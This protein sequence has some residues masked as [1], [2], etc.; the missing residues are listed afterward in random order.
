MINYSGRRFRYMLGF[1]MPATAITLT[2][3][4]FRTSTTPFFPISVCRPQTDQAQEPVLFKPSSISETLSLS[5]ISSSSQKSASSLSQ[6]SDLPASPTFDSRPQLPFEYD[7]NQDQE[8]CD[9]IYGIGYFTHIEKH[10]HPYCESSSSSFLQCF[11]APRLPQ[12]WASQWSSTAGDPFCFARGV[13][14]DPSGPDGRHFKASCNTRDFN[15]ERAKGQ[16]DPSDPL[17]DIAGV[18][19]LA[20]LAEYWGGSGVAAQFKAHWDLKAEVQDCDRDSNGE[21]LFVISREDTPNIWHEM[22]DLWQCLITLDAMQAV[23]NPATGEPWMTQEDIASMQ[24]VFD[25]DLP[26]QRHLEDWWEMLNGKKPMKASE[27]K[28]G[29]CYA[30]V[31]LPL[32]G[33]SSP[34]WGALVEHVYHEPCRSSIIIDAFR[35]RVFKH[36]DLT[37]RPLNSRPNEHPTITFVNRTHNRRLWDA[38]SLMDKIRTRY[39]DSK[40]NVVDFANLPLRE[41]VELATET[42]VFIGHHGA[43]MMHLFFL[44][45]DAAVV[46]IT[47]SRARKFRSITRMRGIT[48]FEANC[49]EEPDY[50]HIAYGK[51]YPQNWRAGMDDKHWQSR[52]YA[53]LIEEDF[54]GWVDAAVRNQRNRRYK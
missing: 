42:D 8:L 26:M 38:D 51:E 53:Y 16:T 30:N 43:G 20:D 17:T 29:A 52:P 33:S 22:M 11:S 14:F 47:S 48:H 50:E 34:F 27:L 6:T 39:P 15:A 35:R 13:L 24:I 4:F 46:E 41:Q 5:Q 28:P 25:D 32:P 9:K 44:P 12:P 21:W 19:N 49:L 3:F 10:Q 2:L 36:L 37:P 54:L 18:P 1:V 40:V 31:L 7:P 45:T 23:R